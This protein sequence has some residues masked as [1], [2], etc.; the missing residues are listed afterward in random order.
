MTKKATMTATIQHDINGYT[1]TD[2]VQVPTTWNDCTLRQA[3]QVYNIITSTNNDVHVKRLMIA[4]LLVTITST[5]IE[6][7]KAESIAEW[8]EEA[9]TA[10]FLDELNAICTQVAD[11]FFEITET[12]D[13]Q[14][15]K[16]YAIRLGLT[17]CPY[18]WVEYKSH[19]QPRR[20]YA[21]A[22][23]FD[24]LTIYELGTVFTLF[25]RWMET[26]NKN[27][28]FTL[29]ATIYRPA[30]PETPENKASGY[31]G[32]IRRPLRGE[33]NKIAQRNS[34][35][36][37]VPVEIIQLIVFWVASCRDSIIKEYPI[38][39]SQKKDDETPEGKNYGWAGLILKLSGGVVNIN[40]VADQPYSTVFLHLAMLEDA[41]R[42]ALLR[43]AVNP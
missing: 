10:F 41:R 21:A 37:F 1:A 23:G 40:E 15:R 35:W 31:H 28:L 6:Q 33:E 24:N 4:K 34:H 14:P 36:E 12:D 11:P 26:N 30:K 17:K 43:K 13:E 29:L 7:M 3:A 27:I 22:D 42:L 8:G 18:P 38:I 39:F 2:T 25:E 5:N 16:E 9:G 32:D 20:L 19:G